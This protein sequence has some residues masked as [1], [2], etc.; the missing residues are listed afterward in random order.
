MKKDK[1]VITKQPKHKGSRL[2]GCQYFT[3]PLFIEILASYTLFGL[4]L[5]CTI[6]WAGSNLE[7]SVCG[8][9]EP[10]L[11]KGWSQAAGT[12][13][14]TRLSELKNIEAVSIKSKDRRIIRGYRL[15]GLTSKN[16]GIA[17]G[18]LLVAQGNTMLAEHIIGQFQPFAENGYDVYI[19][20]YRGYGRSD[21]KPRFKGILSDYKE[22]VDHLNS[23]GYQNSV[24]YG[25]SFGGVVMLNALKGKPGEKRVVIDSARSRFSKYGC[26]KD[27]DPINNLPKN[28]SNFL[29]I[30]GQKDH[31]V[32]PAAS[33]EL[34]K[35]AKQRGA[36]ILEHPKL[37]HPFMDTDRSLHNYRMNTVLFFLLGR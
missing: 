5:T 13:D 21:G 26:P 33:K 27:N 23:L 20:D 16:T 36:L 25:L 35:L 29:L 17:K 1:T 32:T 15:K 28:C 12:P 8:L 2:K 24:F 18:Y 10:V 3:L 22:I 30:A 14:K 6:S 7:Q 31:V 11:F 37:N 4:L 9:E 19:F 34:L